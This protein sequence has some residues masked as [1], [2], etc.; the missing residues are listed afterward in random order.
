M[1]R[2]LSFLLLVCVMLPMEAQR[3]LSLDS[4]RALAIRNN[5]E[6]R[7]SKFKHDVAT[8]VRK[9]AKTKYLPSVDA[10]G[11]YMYTSKEISL[12]ND[13]QKSALSGLGNTVSQGIGQNLSP[14][15]TQMAQQG[16]IT[17]AQASGFGQL[18]TNAAPSLTSALNNL[19]QKIVDDFHTNTHNLWMGSI[20][21]AQPIFMGG[22]I[23]AY[24][25]IAKYS[26][27]FVENEGNATMQETLLNI[28]NAY[29]MVVSLKHKKNLATSYL[30]LTKKLD[31][32]VQKMINEG[33]ATRSDGLSVS[34]RVNE[35]E[36]TL[37]QVEDGLVLSKMLLCQLCGLPLNENITLVDEDRE[38]LATVE[39]SPEADVQTAINNRPELKMLSN[40]VDISKQNVKLVRSDYLPTVALTGG[41]TLSN[42]N[43]FNGFQNKFAG[44]WNVGVLLR[45]PIWHWMEGAYKVRAAKATTNMTSMQLS[46]AQEKIELQVNQST[47]KVKE[48]NKK[49]AMANKNTEKAD[50]NLRCATLGFKE[51]VLPTT[52]VLEAQTAWFMAESQ[53]IDAEI[54]VKLTQ[55]NLKKALGVLQQY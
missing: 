25:N 39:E 31:N 40:A 11:T 35:A 1:K 48:A 14:V 47:F 41:Y 36:M 22:K 29:W 50:E 32:D 10:S 12:L 20:V 3:L 26:E 55:V 2:L 51:G 13:D 5:K 21:V 28:D 43:V 38:T 17:A 23:T 7:I 49:L 34:V 19:G 44:V 45:V 27:M 53:K 37:T 46:D 4:C 30:E 52:N 16:L 18:I 8:N 15:L 54:D 33:V 9:A 24:N 42:P 6:L